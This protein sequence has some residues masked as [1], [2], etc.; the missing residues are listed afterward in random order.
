M[1]KKTC[2]PKKDCF[3]YNKNNHRCSALKQ[4]YCK[5]GE[6]GFYKTRENFCD[7]CKATRYRAVSCE[8]CKMIVDGLM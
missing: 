5:Y 7:K 8:I 1:Q 4:T 3:A 2:E 6:C